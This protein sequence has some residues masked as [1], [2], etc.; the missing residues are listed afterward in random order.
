VTLT[1]SCGLMMKFEWPLILPE[2][3]VVK[4][5][6]AH[7]FDICEYVVGLAK[8]FGLAQGMRPV[9]GGVT[10]H[11]AC[12][13]RAQNMGSKSAEM[14]RMIPGVK[15]DV[16]ERCSGHGGTFGVMKGTHDVA[17]KVGRPAAR[18]AAKAKNETLCSDCPLACKHVGQLMTAE[19]KGAPGPVQA[20]PIEVLARAYG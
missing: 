17:I 12:H 13:A 18:Q 8:A 7:T 19:L 16:V 3:D 10:V 1:A 15:V 9:D 4:R 6:S 14:L 2:S 5:L 11:H 20:H